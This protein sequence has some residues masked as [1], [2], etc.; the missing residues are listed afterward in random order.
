ML[1]KTIRKSIS[2]SGVGLHSGRHVTMTLKPAAENTGIK[3]IRNDLDNVVIPAVADSVVETVLCTKIGS[4]NGVTI[5]TIEHLMAAL[6]ALHIDNL[7]VEVDGPELPIMDGSSVV[8][9]ELIESVGL[10][11][12]KASR[13][14]IKV[15][16]PVRVDESDG[17]FAELLP[18]DNFKVS[19][20][21]IFERGSSLPAQQ[22][23]LSVTPS[24]F[25]NDIARARTV[26]FLEDVEKLRSMG[27]ALGGSLDNAVVISGDQILNPEGLRFDDECVRHKIL[28]TIGD[29]YLAGHPILGHF[30]GYKSGH[31]M[32]CKILKTLFADASAWCFVEFPQKSLFKA[33]YASVASVHA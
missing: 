14:F 23:H 32:N 30:R 31:A 20:D 24:R 2:C 3:F 9:V 15:L 13:R 11:S 18:D 25:K 12:Q 8:F 26:G 4:H 7:I 29:L 1:Q 17:R 33:P 21:F 16:K 6:S 28:D 19:F 22:F 10:R 27:L 5:G